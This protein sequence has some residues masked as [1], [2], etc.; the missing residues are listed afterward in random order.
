MTRPTGSKNPVHDPK[1]PHYLPDVA[2][3]VDGGGKI[4][5]DVFASNTAKAMKLWEDGALTFSVPSEKAIDD[6]TDEITFRR[7]HTG[8]PA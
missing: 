1:H 5:P 2:E 7:T 3:A 8:K 4:K 6:N